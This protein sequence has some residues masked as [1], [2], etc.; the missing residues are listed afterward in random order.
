MIEVYSLVESEDR[1][2]PPSVDGPDAL[3]IEFVA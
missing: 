3:A 1:G 2:R